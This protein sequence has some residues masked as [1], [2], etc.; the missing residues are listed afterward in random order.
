M[1][2]GDLYDHCQ[3]LPLHVSR[4][5]VKDKIEEMH[6]IRVAVVK[7]DLDTTVCRGMY[8]S[9]RNTTRRIVQQLGCHV[10]VL[11]RVG[12]NRCWERFV[13]VKEYMHV[14]DKEDEATDT[15]EA[16]D[17]LL[18]EFSTMKPSPSPQMTSEIKAFWRAMGLLCPEPA[19]QQ[20]HEERAG[21]LSDYQ[22]ALRLRI[23]QLYVPSLFEDWYLEQIESVKVD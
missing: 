14:F 1:P 18:R 10:V 22:I 20:L 2:Y 8:F 17:Q 6:G 16:F 3:P 9:P 12:N 5:L 19:R 7:T 4:K 23:P 11:P 15:G 21:G 13:E